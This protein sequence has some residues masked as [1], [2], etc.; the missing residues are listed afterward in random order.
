MDQEALSGCEG[1][2]HCCET[3]LLASR[4]HPSPLI[5]SFPRVTRRCHPHPTHRRQKEQQYQVC[6]FSFSLLLLLLL[7][8]PAN[9]V[10]RW[11]FNNTSF[12]NI[13][14][15][16]LATPL[17]LERRIS[18]NTHSHTTQRPINQPFST[19]SCSIPSL[20]LSLAAGTVST[21]PQPPPTREAPSSSDPSLPSPV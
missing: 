2:E 21:P 11:M 4:P 3:Q 6:S 1:R 17:P 13:I 9:A 20:T 16:K 5:C 8:Q 15:V 14:L 12:V 10:D 7:P 19:F 18:N